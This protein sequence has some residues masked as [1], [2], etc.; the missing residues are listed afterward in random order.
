MLTDVQPSP[1]QDR[2]RTLP[3]GRPKIAS[4]VKASPLVPAIE[5]RDLGLAAFLPALAVFA[6]TTPERCWPWLADRLA[7]MRVVLRAGRTAEELARLA[8]MV[9]TRS[10]GM[11]LERCWRA[12]LAHNYH[13]WMQLLRCHRGGRWRPRVRLEGGAEI[14]VALGTGRGAILWVAPFAYSDLITKLALHE[15][16]HAVSHLSRDTHGFSTSRFGRRVLNP[17]LTRIER[18][19]LA[20]RLVMTDDHTVG[21]L[22]ELAA[23]LRANRLVSI[24]V[25]PTGQRTRLVPFLDG[26]VRIATGALGLARQSGAP[27]L[28]V[29]TLR[30]PDGGFVTRIEPP[31]PTVA[32]ADRDAALDAMLGAYVALL[33]RYVLQAPDQFALPY[34]AAG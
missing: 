13:A 19:Y 10:L 30:E 28:P 22:R 29:F 6:W 9:G 17:I 33:E 26:R 3:R 21:P 23:R 27:V 20:E 11:P 8:A 5:T 15:A 16:G 24:T 7:G 34:V 14:A 1:R 31:L 2:A 12:H 32:R 4:S 25:A 18:R